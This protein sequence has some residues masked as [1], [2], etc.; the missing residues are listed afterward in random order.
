[1]SSRWVFFFVAVSARAT[2]KLSPQIQRPQLPSFFGVRSRIARAA[3][4][5]TSTFHHMTCARLPTTC[6]AC[7]LTPHGRRPR[8][9]PSPKTR[10]PTPQVRA[11]S[12][13][14]VVVFHV[15]HVVT[16]LASLDQVHVGKV[17]Y[18]T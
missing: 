12:K 16:S 3:A 15:A 8:I 17:L 6:Q 2:E 13:C 5:E 18:Y 9:A 1:M 11:T 7:P 4:S 10:R 14:P